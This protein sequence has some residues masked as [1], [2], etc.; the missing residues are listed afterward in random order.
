V[1]IRDADWK[2][3]YERGAQRRT[4]GYDTGRPLMPHQF[5][6]YDMHADA[7]EL[8]NLAADPAH[9]ATVKRL[10][11]LLVTHLQETA[12]QP[13]LVPVSTDPVVVLDYAVQSHDVAK[14]AKR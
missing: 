14:A 5:R 1:M 13:E 4:D 9:A 3:I 8:H 2:L 11:E 7:A 6:L 12:R 10:T